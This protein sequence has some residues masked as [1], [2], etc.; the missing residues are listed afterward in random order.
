[1]TTNPNQA[2][3]DKRAWYVAEDGDGKKHRVLVVCR[4]HIPRFF[5]CLNEHGEEYVFGDLKL[6]TANV[7]WE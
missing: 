4:S 3:S 1:M 7:V 5:R 6:D 2:K